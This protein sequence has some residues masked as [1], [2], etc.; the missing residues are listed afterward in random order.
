MSNKS[1]KNMSEK[2]TKKEGGISFFD[3]RSTQYGSNMLLMVIAVLGILILINF[4]AGKN[5]TRT[6]FTKNQQFTLSEQSKKILEDVNEPISIV[7]FYQA[8]SPLKDS[9]EDLL[10]EYSASNDNISY[11]FVDPDQ[12]VAKAKLYNIVQYNTLVVEKG[13]KRESVLSSAESDI[14]SAIIRIVKDE[15]KKLYFVTGHGEKSLQPGDERTSYANIKSELEKQIYDI[16]EISLLSEGGI[17][18]DASV[19][20]MAGPKNQIND[21]EKNVLRSYIN[22][23]NGKVLFL[24]DPVLDLGESVDAETGLGMKDFLNEF[25]IDYGDGL[26]VDRVGNLFGDASA[27]VVNEYAPF[28][29]TQGLSQVVL[30]VVAKVGK[31]ESIPENWNVTELATSSVDSWL[32]N[33][34]TETLADFSEEEDE[35][36]PISIAA[37]AQ[38]I[39]PTDNKEGD[40]QSEEEKARIVVIGDSDFAVDPFT[41]PT[42]GAFNAELFINSVNWLAAEEDL[43]SIRPRSNESSTVT[44][45]GSQARWILYATVGIMPLLVGIVGVSLYVRRKGKRKR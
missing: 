13:E 11:E 12:N 25:G 18:E 24:L 3:K 45:T 26:V 2:K 27:V 44:L 32:E 10:K 5:L 4:I 30:P 33:N 14:T 39:T 17:P 40:E 21:D 6:D 8:S 36:G 34:K 28:Q 35:T 9:A 29:I 19:V 41:D 1:E 38:E 37:V 43:I 15:R 42:F 16:E 23:R 7:A 22:N 20:V 31:A